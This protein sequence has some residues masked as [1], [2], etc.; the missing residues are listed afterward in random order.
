MT[1]KNRFV[2]ILAVAAAVVVLMLTVCT[3]ALA[4]TYPL[5]TVAPGET[6]TVAST[7]IVGTLF[8]G[9]GATLKAPEGH[10][11]TM[12]IAGVET[13]IAPGSY[14]GAVLTVTEDILVAQASAGPSMGAPSYYK[15]RTAIY[16]ED[17]KYILSKS[18]PAATTGAV[19]N[20]SQAGDVALR[21]VGP[22]FNGIIAQS[23]AG[24]TTPFNYIVNGLDVSFIGNG[25]NDFSGYGSVLMTDGYADLTV[26]DATIVCDGVIR[27]IATI[28][29]HSTLRINDS[30][31]QISSPPVPT[32]TEGMMQVP[33]ML[34]L[35]GTCR[36]TNIVDYGTEYITNSTV[37][38]Q[39]WGALSTDATKKVR[40]YVKDSLIEVVESGY[41][42]YSIGDSHNYFDNCAINVNDMALIMADEVSCGTFTNGTVVNSGRFGVMM[43]SQNVGILTIDKGS[44]FNCGE[45]VIQPKSAYPEI[46]V[47]GATLNSGTGVILQ[48]MVNDD[49]MATGMPPMDGGDMG[50]APGEEPGA[51][52]AP[53]GAAAAS[54][55]RDINATFSNTTLVGDMINSNTKDC[56]V[57]VSLKNATLTGAITTATVVSEASLRGVDFTKFAPFTNEGAAFAFLIGWVH[58][59]YTAVDDPFGITAT[60]DAESTWMVDETSYLTGLTIAKSGSVTAPA[61]YKVSMTVNGERQALKAG[62]YSGKIVLTVAPLSVFGGTSLPTMTGPATD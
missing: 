61:G 33:W 4:A 35:T 32:V 11:L 5:L 2:T 26:N 13:P 59:T 27:N 24:S 58:N 10:S 62:S 1:R 6:F 54:P 46:I 8:V 38:A 43:H 37:R 45:T 22:K 53:L 18:V 50:G 17:G 20:N 42:S 60:L 9:E 47:D 40:M 7:S 44:V 41:G 34:G 14:S 15:F 19:I 56:N 57:N 21:S 52:G 31:M 51:G 25:G 16:I 49:P 12:T 36:G 55:V 3:G 28:K 48:A 23:S 29:G 30:Y 39:G